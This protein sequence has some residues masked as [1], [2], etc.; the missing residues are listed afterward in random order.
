MLSILYFI[1]TGFKVLLTSFL[2]MSG[3]SVMSGASKSTPDTSLTSSEVKFRLRKLSSKANYSVTR[4]REAPPAPP[5]KFSN[6]DRSRPVSFILSPTSKLSSDT[7]STCDSPTSE[8][9]LLLHQET[10]MSSLFQTEPLYQQFYSNQAMLDNTTGEDMYECVE[11]PDSLEEEVLQDDLV[12]E[13][14]PEQMIKSPRPSAM[15]LTS[16]GGRRS[17]W[18][19]LPEVIIVLM[20]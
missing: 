15:D 6:S 16:S 7:D 2:G 20:Y 11:H 12:Q 8:A 5:R 17:M 13:E 9:V 19:E 18:S 14:A 1:P 3:S 4:P 10:Y